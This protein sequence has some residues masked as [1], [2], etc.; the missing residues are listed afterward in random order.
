MT[1]SVLVVDMFK[2]PL[3]ESKHT[4]GGFATLELAREYARRRTWGAVEE[5]RRR[6]VA[7]ADEVKRR[8]FQFGKN[9]SV[10]DS[11]QIYAEPCGRSRRAD[12]LSH[13]LTMA[14]RYR[15]SR[16]APLPP[17]QRKRMV[18][19]RMTIQVRIIMVDVEA[20]PVRQGGAVWDTQYART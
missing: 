7:G 11:L 5:Q 4:V 18:G 20:T 6:H 15:K 1:Y 13:R 8:W 9:C 16:H 17:I 2:A 19:I 14:H 10:A 12:H 3:K